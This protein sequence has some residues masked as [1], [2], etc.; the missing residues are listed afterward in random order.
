[1]SVQTG[2]FSLVNDIDKIAIKHKG[3]ATGVIKTETD[4]TGQNSLDSDSCLV[5]PGVALIFQIRC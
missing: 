1:M 5:M 2:C 3:I 4:G